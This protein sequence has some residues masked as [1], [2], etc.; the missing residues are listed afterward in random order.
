MSKV[1][2]SFKKATWKEYKLLK[3][4]C[5]KGANLL[6]IRIVG[7]YYWI[8]YENN[9]IENIFRSLIDSSIHL[10]NRSMEEMVTNIYLQLKMVHA[11]CEM[12]CIN[13]NFQPS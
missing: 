7:Q 13:E 4:M 9:I 6:S 1:F 8:P 5:R 10:R 2:I 12:L 11:L 3:E